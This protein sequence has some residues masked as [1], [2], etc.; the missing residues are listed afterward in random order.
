MALRKLTAEAA[1]GGRLL[2]R[3]ELGVRRKLGVRDGQAQYSQR[4]AG[5]DPLTA[6]LGLSIRQTI[7][8]F[9]QTRA[10]Q[11]FSKIS[12]E[13]CAGKCRECL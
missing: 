5:A 6:G 12:Q 7:A 2:L 9:Q 10:N 1:L 8:T 11:F 3:Q 13:I 4:W